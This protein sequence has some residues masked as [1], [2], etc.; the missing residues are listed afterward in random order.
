VVACGGYPRPAAL[1]RSWQED[2]YLKDYLK[3]LWTWAGPPG[4][5]IGLIY[6]AASIDRPWAWWGLAAAFLLPAVFVG[7]PYGIRFTKIIRSEPQ[8]LARIN[9][10]EVENSRLSKEIEVLTER[11]DKGFA[12]GV[13][14]GL[15]RAKAAEFSAT[16]GK[17]P[18]LVNMSESNGTVTLYGE[19]PHPEI[20][21]IKVGTRFKLE[22]PKTRELKGIVQVVLVAPETSLVHMICVEAPFP[23]YWKHLAEEARRDP[24][25]PRGVALSKYDLPEISMEWPMN[26]GELI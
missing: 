25:A 20:M 14:E 17:L 3:K 8:R 16:V 5:I 13:D 22:V 1:H 18:V 11:E 9:E 26:N 7:I 19:C 24:S 12:K 10:L 15:R 2:G 6:G 21:D 23:A 4:V